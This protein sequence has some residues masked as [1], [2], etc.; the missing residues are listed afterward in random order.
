MVKMADEMLE[1]EDSEVKNFFEHVVGKTE[2]I[3]SQ[4]S[5]ARSECHISEVLTHIDLLERTIRLPS[6][7]ANI[8]TDDRQLN[9]LRVVFSELLERFLQHFGNSILRPSRVTIVPCQTVKNG[10]PGKPSVD[11]PP[12][13]LED[14]RGLGFT[15]EK[16]ARIFRVSRWT[17]MRRVRSFDLEHLSLFS[18]MSD[19]EIES[20][21]QD[22][23]ARHGSTTGE[24]CIQFP[25]CLV[26]CFCYCCSGRYNAVQR[27]FY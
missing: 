12:E 24:T 26:G 14:L 27:I 15:W 23:I 25:V 6:Q 2:E 1:D 11:I 21:I 9:D 22:F 19:E 10:R 18:T 7:L 13:V 17:I 8:V 5:F 20:I 4:T 3:L 16:I